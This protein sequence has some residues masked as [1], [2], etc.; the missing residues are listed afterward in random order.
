MTAKQLHA[1][2]GAKHGASLATVK[3]CASAA[4]KRSRS[5]PCRSSP[6]W[7]EGKGSCGEGPPHGAGPFEKR[8]GFSHGRG[9][10]APKYLFVGLQFG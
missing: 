7:A 3:R 9:S 6:S 8:G 5:P 10:A 1:A 4:H 2:L